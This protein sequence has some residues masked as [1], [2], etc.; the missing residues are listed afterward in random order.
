MKIA[1]ISP[2]SVCET[3]IAQNQ[4][5]FVHCLKD[6][7]DI[8]FFAEKSYGYDGL[9]IKTA[10]LSRLSACDALH[11]QWGNNPL[12][13]FE[14]LL[15]NKLVYAGLRLP[16][17]STLHEIHLPYLF[18]AHADVEILK[19]FL[20]EKYRHLRVD[21]TLPPD[22]RLALLTLFEVISYS[23]AT[24]VNSQY[25]ADR[26]RVLADK[27]GFDA[28]R[29]IAAHLGIDSARLDREQIPEPPAISFNV[30]R[31]KMIFT[32]IGHLHEIKSVDLTIKAFGRFKDTA[33]DRFFFL[34]AGDG[35]DRARL[36][37]L[38][39]STIPGRFVFTGYVNDLSACYAASDVV[40][41]P[42]SF[43]RGETSSV[44]PE[45]FSS[46]KP[47]IAPDLGCNGEYV[48]EQT[49][50][51]ARDNSVDAYAEA[52]GFM[53][54]NPD[55]TAAR[56]QHAKEFATTVLDWRA[57]AP[58]FISEYDQLQAEVDTH[59]PRST[60]VRCL[61]FEV[62]YRR[63]REELFQILKKQQAYSV[64]GERET[65]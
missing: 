52:I 23:D 10:R 21:K 55:Q 32:Y 37:E 27:T 61:R 1:L 29:I 8:R 58:A 5:D 25:A 57:Q 24:V 35:P 26:L 63:R 50:Y 13:Y 43:S 62:L 45:A 28:G 51:L 34:I 6:S 11:F 15:L 22:E 30:P 42:R 2:G 56:G 36:E 64:G 46:G 44:I 7:I 65:T 20:E 39:A 38:A 19:P 33:L 18:G 54:K 17:I 53:L 41:N 14:Y 60:V 48:T 9:S 49:G 47:I 59:R 16:V 3:A 31:D 4:I 12:H 40:V